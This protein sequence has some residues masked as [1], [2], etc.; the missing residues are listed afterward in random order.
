MK[1]IRGVVKRLCFDESGA[2]M[3]LVALALVVIVGMAGLV[4]DSGRLYLENQK[5]QNALDAAALA[6]AQE[7]PNTNAATLAALEYAAL[8]GLNPD[9]LIIAFPSSS[10]I[11]VEYTEEVKTY[12]LPVL[13][14]NEIQ[15]G[16]L[17]GA[18]Q[19]YSP[20]WGSYTLFSAS[21]SKDLK[22]SGN[23]YYIEGSTHTNDDF[24][25]SGNTLT[26]TGIC[27]AVGSISVNGNNM[28][29]PHR[30]AYSSHIDLPD[31][32]EQVREQAESAGNIYHTN[33]HYN[34]NSINVE[35]SIYVDGE[36]HLNGNNI[37]GCGAILAEDDIHINGNTIYNGSSDAICL[38][39]LGDIHVN[40]NDLTING[41]L[42]APNGEIKINGNNITIN[43]K[44]IS[45]T[46]SLS[47]NTLNIID[48]DSALQ[49]LPSS[50]CRL[51]I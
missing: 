8:N 9:E 2:V 27:D 22:I 38:Y 37:I 43:G 23:T 35:N 32:S 33:I 6:G 3:V 7:L 30:R 15:A 50:G 41:I 51:V 31:Y 45:N 34:G 24:K 26:I 18:S 48:D 20:A 10:L 1:H 42:Y 19:D 47:G 29:I 46:I 13:G 5:I 14:I 49:A 25:A 12:F 28:D 4:I 44:V 36:V 11:T 39:S 21:P 40:G 16:K 17:A